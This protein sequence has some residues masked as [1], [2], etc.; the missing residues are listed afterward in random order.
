MH[1]YSTADPAVRVSKIWSPL[2]DRI[3]IQIDM[4]AVRFQELRQEAGENPP[5]PFARELSQVKQISARALSESIQYSSLDRSSW[6][7][8]YQKACQFDGKSLM[9][10]VAENHR[11]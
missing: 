11:P 10:Q 5:T 2:L 1:V 3:D 7:S 4:A 9:A 6:T 8:P